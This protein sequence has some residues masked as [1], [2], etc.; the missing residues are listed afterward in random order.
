MSDKLTEREESFARHYVDWRDATKAYKHAYD[1]RGMLPNT[2]WRKSYEVRN[3]DRVKARID[4]LRQKLT[5]EMLM[6][7]ADLCRDAA[8]IVNA[9]ANLIIQHQHN[10]C[11][12]CFGLAHKWQWMNEAEFDI[13]LA[14]AMD[15][16]AETERRNLK[17]SAAEQVDPEPLPNDDG[18]YGFVVDRRPNPGCPACL[19]E[20]VARVWVADTRDLGPLEAKL[21]AGIKQT[22]DGIQIVTRDQDGAMDKL[23]RVLG[24]YKDGV[25]G[26]K[27]ALQQGEGSTATVSVTVPGTPQEAAD[28]Y[29]KFIRE[30]P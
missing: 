11:R 16:N 28:F 6:G 18:G 7:V 9:D 14:A 30:S 24:A 25:P 2:I 4:E 1:T 23:L 8:K 12:C 13:A 19:G 5:D 27:V 29:M 21:Y 3:R 17:R 15:R 26:L 10:N 22:K 20:G